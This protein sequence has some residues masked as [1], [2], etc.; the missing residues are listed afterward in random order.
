[1]R[2][3]VRDYQN[4]IG[5]SRNSIDSQT[6]KNAKWKV[7]GVNSKSELKSEA[8]ERVKCQWLIDDSQTW[9]F[10]M[11]NYFN[12]IFKTF[13]FLQNLCVLHLQYFPHFAVSLSSWSTFPNVHP[14]LIIRQ[15]HDFLKKSVVCPRPRSFHRLGSDFQKISQ[16]SMEKWLKWWKQTSKR[17]RHCAVNFLSNGKVHGISS[18][19]FNEPFKNEKMKLDDLLVRLLHCVG[20]LRL[21]YNFQRKPQNC[22]EMLLCWS[23]EMLKR[24]TPASDS[25]IFSGL[26]EQRKDSQIVSVETD[27]SISL[28]V[29]L[30]G[31]MKGAS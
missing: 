11:Q 10:T 27:R 22:L 14:G 25:V 24:W 7:V 13:Q 16:H 8:K 3:V 31:P 18:R 23:V 12:Q 29:R 19:R 1:M 6:G 26:H 5:T 15:A 9:T 30:W 21:R 2:M 28:D 17:F 20:R 4:L